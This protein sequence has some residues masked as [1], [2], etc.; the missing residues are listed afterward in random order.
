V[1]LDQDVVVVSDVIVV[2]CD[3]SEEV[4]VIVEVEL[5]FIDVPLLIGIVV[6]EVVGAL[7]VETTKVNQYQYLTF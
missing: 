2:I 3:V 1:E 6:I 5:V 4:E 7:S